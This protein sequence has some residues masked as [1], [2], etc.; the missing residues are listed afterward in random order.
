MAT[1]SLARDLS[2]CQAW[3]LNLGCSLHFQFYFQ[4]WGSKESSATEMYYATL[5]KCT[6]AYATTMD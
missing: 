1:Q 3:F 5:K 4:A 2:P 6:T